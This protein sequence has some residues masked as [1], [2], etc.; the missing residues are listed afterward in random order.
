[1]AVA[2]LVTVSGLA[3][4]QN[5]PRTLTLYTSEVQANVQQHIDL[6]KSQNAGVGVRLFR[7]GTGEV[8]AKLEAKFSAN[9]PQA[10]LLWARIRRT[11]NDYREKTASSGSRRP[12]AARAPR[13][14]T[15]AASTLRCANCSM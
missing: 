14:P 3:L 15:R 13:T 10:D 6:F 9:N 12:S 11:F 7:S 8:T 5:A 2:A 4:S 1:M